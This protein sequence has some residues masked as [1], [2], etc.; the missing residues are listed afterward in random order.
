MIYKITIITNQR[1][2]HEAITSNQSTPIKKAYP[3]DK[4]FNI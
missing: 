2:A 1:Y 4:P 3:S